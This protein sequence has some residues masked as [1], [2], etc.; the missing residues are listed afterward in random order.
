[1]NDISHDTAIQLIKDVLAKGVKVTEVYVDTVGPPHKY[2]AKLKRVFPQI[3]KIVVSKKADSLFPIVSAASI[4]AK[5]IR[6]RLLKTWDFPEH[7]PLISDSAVATAAA[8]APV[9]PAKRQQPRMRFASNYGSGYPADPI[10]KAWL[11]THFDPIFG[12]PTLIRFSWGTIDAFFR[13]SGA[14]VEW[15]KEDEDEYQEP[16][17]KRRRRQSVLSMA[18]EA[19]NTA[20]PA[21]PRFRY[22]ADRSLHLVQSFET[23]E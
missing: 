4:C 21:T 18:A 12:F 14:D 8:G 6:D 17:Q 23:P 10:T 20:P 3:P 9:S 16:T 15:S 13:S 22:F 7:Q 5:V 11:K 2:E 19:K 1:M